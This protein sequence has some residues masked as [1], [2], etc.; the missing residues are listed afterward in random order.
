MEVGMNG[1]GSTN[2]GILWDDFSSQSMVAVGD[3]DVAEV[4]SLIR[5][6]LADCNPFPP[7]ILT[8]VCDAF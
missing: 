5:S 2:A 4:F 8:M 1:F 7:M 3:D 6:T